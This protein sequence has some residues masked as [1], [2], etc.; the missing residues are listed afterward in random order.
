MFSP[1]MPLRDSRQETIVG[2]LSRRVSELGF[3]R[4]I[5]L[6]FDTNYHMIGAV[7]DSVSIYY[8]VDPAFPRPGHENDEVETCLRSDL[9]YAVSQRYKD[10]LARYAAKASIHIV[11]HGFAVDHARAVASKSKNQRPREMRQLKPKIVGYVGS[12]H[13]SYIDVDLLERLASERPDYDF[14]LVGPYKN[15]PLGPDLSPVG[16]R[17]IRRL[18]NVH[19]LGPRPFLDV[20]RYT[21]H[22][23]AGMVLVNVR[24]YREQYQTD[25]RT[26]FKW[27]AYFCLGLP[28]VA[29]RLVEAGGIDG[30]IYAADDADEYLLQLDRA[31]SEANDSELRDIRYHYATQFSFD[32]VLEQITTP[33]DDFERSRSRLPPT[34]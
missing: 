30:L 29:P 22:F 1:Y 12:I 32:R 23:S 18:A 8:C 4:T 5:L 10:Q 20:P 7:R 13:D 16:L 28:V 21:C 3:D 33:I 34:F 2:Q 26:H 19:L 25:R 14:V 6:N 31:L 11:P 17:R 15:N 27:L 24:Q 9:I